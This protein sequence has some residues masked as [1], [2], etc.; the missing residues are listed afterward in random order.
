MRQ[1]SLIRKLLLLASLS[2]MITNQLFAQRIPTKKEQYAQ[3]CVQQQRSIHQSLNDKAGDTDF[4]PYC[5][6]VASALEKRLTPE[7]FQ[8]L[9]NKTS[10]SKPA[11]LKQVETQASRSCMTQEPKLQV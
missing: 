5:A 9:G 7:Q 4:K 10:G 3:Q 8:S 1:S 2:V 6:C 11:W